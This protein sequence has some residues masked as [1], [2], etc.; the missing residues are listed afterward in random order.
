MTANATQRVADQLHSASIH[1]LRR[2][3]RE[4]EAGGIGPARLSA[5]SVIVHAGPLNLGELASAEQVRPPTMTRIVNG[6]EEDGLVRR[7]TGADRRV[8]ELRATAKGVR[9]LERARARRLALVRSGLRGL[10]KADL[11][12]LGRAAEVMEGLARAE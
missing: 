5:L 8:T 11:A 6:L 4:D 12:A 3:A 9:A 1:F 10:S 2:V 7:S